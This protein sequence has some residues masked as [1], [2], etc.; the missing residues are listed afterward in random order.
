[1]SSRLRSS[2]LE[3]L[4]KARTSKNLSIYKKGFD[5]STFPKP[6]RHRKFLRLSISPD[7]RVLALTCMSHVMYSGL[8]QH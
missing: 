7:S 1:L 2:N 5:T 8:E 3:T 4:S 6:N